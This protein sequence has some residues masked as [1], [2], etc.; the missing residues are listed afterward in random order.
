MEDSQ[1]ILGLYSRRMRTVTN[2]A[3]VV[4]LP[5]RMCDVLDYAAW[6][7]VAQVRLSI[8]LCLSRSVPQRLEMVN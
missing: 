5:A 1:K 6:F 2:E 3:Q 7:Y 4:G 8:D